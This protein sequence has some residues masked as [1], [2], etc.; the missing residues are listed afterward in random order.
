MISKVL[1]EYKTDGKFL[2]LEYR[3]Q[4]KEVQSNLH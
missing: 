3:E 4:E 1:N 2:N